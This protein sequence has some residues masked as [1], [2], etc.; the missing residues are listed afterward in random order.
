[1]DRKSTSIVNRLTKLVL[2]IIILQTILIGAA[3]IAGGMI[4]QA[5]ENAYQLFHDKV[6]NRKDYLQRE[7]KNNWTNF[8]PYLQNMGEY[9]YDSDGNDVL[10]FPESNDSIY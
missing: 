7:M 10:F 5:E 3:L 8:Q 6:A 2:G 4:D 1:M 9:S